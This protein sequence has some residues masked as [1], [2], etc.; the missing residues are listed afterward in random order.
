MGPRRNR[1][2]TGGGPSRGGLHQKQSP[3]SNNRQQ[4]NES[5]RQWLARVRH[6][7]TTHG[8]ITGIPTNLARE[9]SS[10]D[11]DEDDDKPAPEGAKSLIRLKI[12]FLTNLALAFGDNGAWDAP[13]IGLLH[14]DTTINITTIRLARWKASGLCS[15][16]SATTKQFAQEFLKIHKA[17]SSGGMVDSEILKGIVLRLYGKRLQK[18]I[19]TLVSLWRNNEDK[20]HQTMGDMTG[21]FDEDGH[22]ARDEGIGDAI[23]AINGVIGGMNSTLSFHSTERQTRLKDIISECCKLFTVEG[24]FAR[25]RLK[26]VLGSSLADGI[27]DNILILNQPIRSVQTFVRMAQALR[28]FHEIEFKKGDLSVGRGNLSSSSGEHNKSP[29]LS[30]VRSELPPSPSSANPNVA[31]IRSKPDPT[32]SSVRSEVT[33]ST[34]STNGDGVFISSAPTPTQVE[35]ILSDIHP[36]L[37]HAVLYLAAC[38]SKNCLPD[39][40]SEGYYLFGFA[41]CNETHQ[42]FELYKIILKGA[43]SHNAKVVELCLALNHDRIPQ[44]FDRYGCGS[45]RSSLPHLESFLVAPILE[46][47]TVF[48]LVQFLRSKDDTSPKRVLIRDYGFHRCRTREQ[49]NVLKDIYIETLNRISVFRLHHACV[50]CRLL[51]TVLDAQVS[52]EMKYKNLLENQ[53]PLPD[54]DQNISSLIA[55]DQGRFKNDKVKRMRRALG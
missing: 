53:G 18:A 31:L 1:V 47:P 23:V 7:A 22:V 33:A 11:D 20:I 46:R 10:C 52:F 13:T 27:Y 41:A 48:R 44:W 16:L 2:T 24:G 45:F 29:A 55:Y 32:K 38:V 14:E 3:P 17:Y 5:D 42:L 37:K 25:A 49:V 12:R 26:S 6:D 19:D 8:Y 40:R 36:M 50:N 30:P 51:E 34:R 54:L 35:E 4:H 9:V 43:A 39:P 21:V 28:R 15:E